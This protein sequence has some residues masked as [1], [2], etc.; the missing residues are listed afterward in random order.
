M[1]MDLT[2]EEF[3]DQVERICAVTTLKKQ[4]GL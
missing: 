2:L 3:L 4:M 1:K